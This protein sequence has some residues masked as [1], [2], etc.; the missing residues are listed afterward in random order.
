MRSFDTNF[1]PNPFP[2]TTSEIPEPKIHLRNPLLMVHPQ[3]SSLPRE[4][5]RARGWPTCMETHAE[6]QRRATHR[7]IEFVFPV[8]APHNRPRCDAVVGATYIIIPRRGGEEGGVH[9]HQADSYPRRDA[10]KECAKKLAGRGAGERRWLR[11]DPIPD[12]LIIAL[13]A[14]KLILK[15]GGAGA[16]LAPR[17]I[18]AL[19]RSGAREGLH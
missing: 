10:F 7:D 5:R 3:V 11:P 18:G 6:S 13:A 4:I 8:V 12:T 14:R 1:T 15:S 16:C 19:I 17:G 2:R 9:S